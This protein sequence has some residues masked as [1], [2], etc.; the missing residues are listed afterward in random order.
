MRLI[1]HSDSIFEQ[2]PGKILYA[3]GI[4]QDSFEDLE[5]K[6]PKVVLH[7]GLPSEE[8]I[9]QEFAD[10][11]HGLIIL[12]DL[13]EEIGRSREICNLFIRDM[14]HKNISVLFLYQ[15]LFHQSR[16]MRTISLN[17]LYFVL[18]KTF[19][20]KAQILH[21]ARQMF[22]DCPALAMEA[23]NDAVN[24]K[25]RGGYLV[26]TNVTTADEED[27]LATNIFLGEVLTVYHP[28]M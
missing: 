4:F 17:L 28:K 20:D 11:K 24:S 19:R 9:S 23:Y 3:Y 15:N 1:K 27:R 7:E 6:F 21:L 26:I 8:L 5:R 13:V 18:M 22:P 25:K 12:D 10:I 14:H 16:F 2:S